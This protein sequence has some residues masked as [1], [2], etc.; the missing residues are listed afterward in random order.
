MFTNSTEPGNSQSRRK[1]K[2]T[3]GGEGV[4]KGRGVGRKRA[5]EKK[6]AEGGTDKILGNTKL[7]RLQ[8]HLILY[9]LN[10]RFCSTKFSASSPILRLKK[11]LDFNN[12][13]KTKVYL[14]NW[15]KPWRQY[16]FQVDLHGL[17][18][19][20]QYIHNSFCFCFVKHSRL[21]DYYPVQVLE[22]Q[23]EQFRRFLNTT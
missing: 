19:F 22:T 21:S 6:V 20:H 8:V 3:G 2:G 4:V 12:S 7:F 5:R 18:G 9:I 14:T 15:I 17:F 16:Q 13:I 1:G 10:R 11:I 23:S